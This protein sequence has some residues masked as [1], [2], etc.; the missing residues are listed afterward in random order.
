MAKLKMKSVCIVAMKSDKKRLMGHL[1]KLGLLEISDQS[2]SDGFEKSESISE[3]TQ[4]ESMLSQT[5]EARETLKKTAGIKSG[6][7]SSLN[8]RREL[9]IPEYYENTEKLKETAAVCSDIN[10]LSS[11]ISQCKSEIARLSVALDEMQPYS[12]LG[13]PTGLRQTASCAVFIGSVKGQYDSDLLKSALSESFDSPFYC[14]SVSVSAMQSC[15][16]AVCLKADKQRFQSALSALGFAFTQSAKS[17]MTPAESIK[18]MTERRS[19][20]ESDIE[21]MTR[22]IAGFADRLENIEFLADFYAMRIDRYREYDKLLQSKNAVIISGYIPERDAP[23]LQKIEQDYNA[24]VILKDPEDDEDVPVELSNNAFSRPCEGILRMYSPPSKTDID[25]TAPM[26]IFFYIFFGLMLSDAGYGLVIALGCIILLLKFNMEDKLKNNI[27]MFLYCGISTMF[28]GVLFGGYF[29]DLIYRVSDHFF[30]NPIIVKPV[31]LDP[32]K[33]PMTLLIF[34]LALGVVH[35]FTGMIINFVNLCRHGRVKDALFD[36]GLWLIVLSGAV[37]LAVGIALGVSAANTAGLIMMAAG[38]VGLVLTQGRDKKGFGKVISGIA[39]LYDITSYASDILSYS[40]VM[41]L[42]LATGVLAQVVNILGTMS[43]G[44][45][46]VIMFI[47]IFLFGTAISLS[48]NAL[49][50][51]VHTI[52]LQYVEFFNKF[53]EGGGRFFKPFSANTK[54]IRFKK[55]KK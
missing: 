14:E 28:W 10:S 36:V 42:G 43:D 24:C 20:L 17:D 45:L 55:P 8:G 12:S 13:I 44:V 26:S 50:A 33:E 30:G 18:A 49:G 19:A 5:L 48:M 47:V 34:G 29:G 4:M 2:P 41:A 25:P 21:V 35:I 15:I 16:F 46:G 54:F 7:L 51:Y 31:W 53:Y 40:R 22:L 37:A 9:T 11:Q 3:R 1:Q 23:E 38:A 39:S 52:R 27:K 32:L 6:L